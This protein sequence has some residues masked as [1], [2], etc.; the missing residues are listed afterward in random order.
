MARSTLLSWAHQKLEKRRGQ[1]GHCLTW[2]CLNRT[3]HPP[4][5]S[6]WGLEGAGHGSVMVHWCARF[7]LC[8]SMKWSISPTSWTFTFKVT[9]QNRVVEINL[10]VG[11]P[12][13]IPTNKK[14]TTRSKCYS[15]DDYKKKHSCHTSECTWYFGWTLIGNLQQIWRG[16]PCK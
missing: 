7:N 9:W 10:S 15:I 13:R 1:A 4:Q 14:L 2:N 8:F 16:I 11:S 5:G 12:F 3:E 6:L